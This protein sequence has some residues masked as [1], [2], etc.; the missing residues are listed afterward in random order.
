MIHALHHWQGIMAT[1]R[2]GRVPAR[3]A[4]HERA[5]EVAPTYS[6]HT[7]CEHTRNILGQRLQRGLGVS[8][9]A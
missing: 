6:T 2:P 8:T 9:D 5:A 1:H 4:F 7:G 3:Q